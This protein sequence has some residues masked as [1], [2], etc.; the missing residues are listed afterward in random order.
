MLDAKLHINSTISDA[1]RGARYFGV[2]IKNFYLGTPMKYFQYIHVLAKMIPQEVW[3]D[4][5]YTPHVAA[6]GF[7]YL[8]IR[9]CMY[10]LKEAGIIAFELSPHGYKPAPFPPGL[11]HH[12]SKPTTFTLCIDNFG[13]KYFSKRD[14]LHLVA[15]LQED[16]EITTDWTGLLYCGL[17][18][19]WH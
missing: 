15:A 1:H 16:Y 18:L 6:N 2:N 19:D 7:V 12:K 11:W 4:P 9:R 10:G 3:D 13:I 14:A 5:C 8:E 17:T